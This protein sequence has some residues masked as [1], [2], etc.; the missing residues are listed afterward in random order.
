[1]YNWR[2][3]RALGREAAKKRGEIKERENNSLNFT[4]LTQDKTQNSRALI[5]VKNEAV[6][7]QSLQGDSSYTDFE[8][9][10]K[11]RGPGQGEP[12]LRIFIYLLFAMIQETKS[13]S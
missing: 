7:L 9:N 13:P 11:Q 8:K 6:R 3:K 1:M 2:D 10:E 5:L 12:G 4:W